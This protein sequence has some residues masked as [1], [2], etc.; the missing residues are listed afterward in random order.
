MNDSY[1]LNDNLFTLI[2]IVIFAIGYYLITILFLLFM[3]STRYKN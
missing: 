1:H 2:I 3:L